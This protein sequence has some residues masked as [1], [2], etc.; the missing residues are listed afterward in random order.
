[1]G[2]EVRQM[3]NRDNP[4]GKEIEELLK[5]SGLGLKELHKICLGNSHPLLC[6]VKER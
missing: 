3:G 2:A 6:A 4:D 5:S 1:M